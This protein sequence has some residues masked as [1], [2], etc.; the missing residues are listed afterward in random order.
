M[1]SCFD[2]RQSTT[3]HLIS[4]SRI[5]PRLPIHGHRRLRSI[6]A[7]GTSFCMSF[8]SAAMIRQ[9]FLVS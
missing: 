2:S 8:A 6:V 9:T 4:S 5:C 7:F 1:L 3:N